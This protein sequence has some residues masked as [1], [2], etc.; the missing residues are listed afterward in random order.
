M[1]DS[2]NSNNDDDDG[3]DNTSLAT[4]DEA[5]HLTNL[6]PDASA[7]FSHNHASLEDIKDECIV[8]LDGNVLLFPY[9]YNSASI[10]ELEKLYNKLASENRLIVPA[11]AAREFYKHRSSKVAK[12]TENIDGKIKKLNEKAID[13][14]IPLLEDND[15]YKAAIEIGNE[16]NAKRTE[17]VKILKTVSGTLKDEI[18]ADRVSNLYRKI[19]S[20][21]VKD[22][23][24]TEPKEREALLKEAQR[25][26]KHKI[27]PGFKDGSKT[28]G[29]IGDY[30]IWLTALQ[31]GKASKKHCIF[32]TNEEKNDWWIKSLG[33]FQPRPELLDEYRRETDG[34]SVHLMPLSDLLE[35]FG[36]LPVTVENAKKVEKI[37]REAGKP[38]VVGS[39]NQLFDSIL[40]KSPDLNVP[41]KYGSSIASTPIVDSIQHELARRRNELRHAS[42]EI[43]HI[44]SVYD[45]DEFGKFHDEDIN[46]RYVSW[47]KERI[48]LKKQIASLESHLRREISDSILE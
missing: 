31:E 37:N 45:S 3:H 18:A 6:Y 13:T 48:K 28:D 16:I 21:N 2:I 19:L 10:G 26:T 32:V 11:H 1:A 4:V 7:L 39:V 41:N 43:G 9:E 33:T 15:T 30:L 47:H 25:R 44:E 34:N 27:P 23:P 42:Y 14:K 5:F 40:L 36:A 35:L 8:V 17:L 38:D 29:G 24:C 46:G 22:I 20:D 12:I